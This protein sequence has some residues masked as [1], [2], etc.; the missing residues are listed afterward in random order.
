VVTS[1]LRVISAWSVVGEIGSWDSRL[2]GAS[3]TWRSCR[4]EGCT[5]SG[6]GAL[7]GAELGGNASDGCASG[8]EAADDLVLFDWGEIVVGDVV[9]GECALEGDFVDVVPLG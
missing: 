9:A 4:A 8:G 1:A 5:S 7:G 6:D 3:S 2:S